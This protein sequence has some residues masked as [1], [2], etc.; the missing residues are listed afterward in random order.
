MGTPK[1]EPAKP[2]VTVV[3]DVTAQPSLSS[4][5]SQQIPAPQGLPASATSAQY[6]KKEAQL[7]AVTAKANIAENKSRLDNI[8]KLR[9]VIIDARQF[10]VQWGFTDSATHVYS[11]VFDAGG[12]ARAGMANAKEMAARAEQGFDQ[13]G[14]F[15]N[16]AEAAPKKG[17]IQGYQKAFESA[18]IKIRTGL[19]TQ[20]KASE[21]LAL[22]DEQKAT[23]ARF[24][25]DA[26][27][28]IGTTIGTGGGGALAKGAMK[29][30]FK[31]VQ[32]KIAQKLAPK[33]GEALA[34]KVAT[35]LG[36][37]FSVLLADQAIVNSPKFA[38]SLQDALL[39]GKSVDEAVKEAA[40]RY[41]F[42]TITGL[43]ISEGLGAAGQKIMANPKVQAFMKNLEE[44]LPQ[45][46]GKKVSDWVSDRLET[47]SKTFKQWRADRNQTKFL[48]GVLQ[49]S[50]DVQRLVPGTIGHDF[51]KL[52]QRMSKGL[53]SDVSL[54]RITEQMLK[55]PDITNA[56]GKT[57]MEA[58]QSK[59]LRGL[60]GEEIRKL[61]D[62]LKTM[63]GKAPQ[64]LAGKLGEAA[65]L[66]T[67]M[68][69]HRQ[70]SLHHEIWDKLMKGDI[71]TLEQLKAAFPGRN[72]SEKDLMESTV[73][74]V[75]AWRQARGYDT[76][77][78]WQEIAKSISEIKG[79]SP[80]LGESL[81]KAMEL[82]RLAERSGEV[83]PWAENLLYYRTR[84]AWVFNSTELMKTIGIA[85]KQ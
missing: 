79:K 47:Y 25:R 12:G 36:N 76:T 67:M 32:A 80:I 5:A 30:G 69:L 34:G 37:R 27:I 2:T 61:A 85:P 68:D 11:P 59:G 74:V 23:W 41:A 56:I 57:A 20:S 54:D 75:N 65:A 82:Q 64:Q 22:K 40:G 15:L 31:A 28:D 55:N 26:A 53:M 33:L 70:G 13:A 4:A 3:P 24:H 83:A 84:S 62:V 10:Q 16:E 7:N 39:K 38:T 21:S 77:R 51:D 8:Q 29:I 58:L 60:G 18:R 6:K 14:Q 43:A 35:A 73:D 72:I 9:K 42:D 44:K 78:T 49:H 50:Q 1:I 63:Q 45:G 81:E 66:K 46:V 19:D 71:K 48:E 52:S 17:D